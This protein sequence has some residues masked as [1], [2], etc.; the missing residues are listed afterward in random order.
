MYY[1][2]IPVSYL[3]P[4]N[5]LEFLPLPKPACCS[6]LEQNSHSTSTVTALYMFDTLVGSTDLPGTHLPVHCP[7]SRLFTVSELRHLYLSVQHSAWTSKTTK[8]FQRLKCISSHF[9]EP[10]YC[11]YFH[12][13]K[14][15]SLFTQVSCK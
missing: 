11:S 13:N 12:L 10:H 14:T 7:L 8:T 3:L 9:S 2:V 1:K 5:T 6:S 15:S 4:S